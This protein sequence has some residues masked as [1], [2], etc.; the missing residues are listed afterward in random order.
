M[1]DETLQI[2]AMLQHNP[3]AYI[4]VMSLVEW[5]L[6]FPRATSMPDDYVLDDRQLP[7]CLP[8]EYDTL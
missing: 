7:K 6:P 5:T 1:H 8:L 3:S 4:T 2:T